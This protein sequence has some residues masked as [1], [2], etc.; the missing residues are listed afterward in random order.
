[1][2]D[3]SIKLQVIDDS[4]ATLDVMESDSTQLNLGNTAVL[5]DKSEPYPGPYIVIPEPYN[6]VTL[7]TRDKHTMDNITVQKIPLFKASN[8]SGGMTVSIAS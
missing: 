4:I 2:G 7:A 5:I 1:M 3:V 8:P 6:D